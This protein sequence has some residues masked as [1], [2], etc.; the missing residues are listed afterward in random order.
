MH[1]ALLLL[2]L[3]C[4]AVPA[5]ADGRVVSSGDTVYVGEENLDL[6][7]LFAGAPAGS[8]RL[9]HTGV[10][11]PDN[12]IAVPNRSS[13]DLTAGAVDGVTGVYTVGRQWVNVTGS[14]RLDVVL[15]GSP[16]ASVMG[17]RIAPGR[18]VDL[19]LTHGRPAGGAVRITLTGPSGV[20]LTERA[21]TANR[22]VL[23]VIDP[24]DLSPGFYAARATVVAAGTAYPSNSVVFAVAP[25]NEMV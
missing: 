4:I 5:A 18:P 2:L 13:F 20:G 21:L 16:D 17:E 15:D 12:S 24:A 6:T 14:P 9:V 8:D 19:V 7:P 25:E 3:L 22:T 11:G 23:A 10:S 1:R